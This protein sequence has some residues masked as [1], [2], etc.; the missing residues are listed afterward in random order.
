MKVIFK[1]KETLGFDIE[2][3]LIPEPKEK[4]I[5]V[6]VKAA[7]IC[8]SDVKFYK[9]I[10]W[11]KN[12]VGS[13]PFIPGHECSGEVIEIGKKVKTIRVGDRVAAETHIPCGKCWQCRH[14]RP[15]ACQK[16]ELFG[17]TVNGCFAEYCII[18]E[19][20]TRKLPEDLPFKKGCLLEPMG[21]P[22]RA[23]YKGKVGKDS[24]VVIGCGPIG[25]FAI[26]IS[27]I[28][29]AKKTI[30]VDVNEKRLNIARRMGATHTVNPQ[31]GSVVDEVLSLTE[32]NGAGVIIEAS[33]NVRALEQAF[34]YLRVGGELFIIGH[35]E[36]LLKI[37][38]SL[39]IVFKEAK[40]TGLFG[41]EIWR[42]WE[43]AEGLLSTGKINVNPIVTH[44][45]PLEDFESAFK[46]AI[47]DEG[48][49]ILLIP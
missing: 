25:Q 39:Q 18:P 21:I 8:G 41:R 7:A 27:V 44:E 42:T 30:A 15:H 45:F 35:P 6:K 28:K 11:C 48:C 26:G 10:P 37:D 19:V 29:G 33:G 3:I 2:D 5:L 36:E 20:A 23:V 16:M 22:L 4:E 46:I 40:I 32:G 14:N 31:K 1:K 17:H 49:K 34:N 13:L 38:V 43:I 9:W 24:V 12:V 47:S